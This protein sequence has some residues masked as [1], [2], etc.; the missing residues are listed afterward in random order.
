MGALGRE[1]PGKTDGGA[2]FSVA[3]AFITGFK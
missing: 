3:L 2:V 1:E